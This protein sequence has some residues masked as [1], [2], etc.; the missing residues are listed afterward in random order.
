MN[1]YEYISR[2]SIKFY[3]PFDLVAKFTRDQRRLVDMQS[4]INDVSMSENKEVKPL[5]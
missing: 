1:F 2:D 3:N 5:L 4:F